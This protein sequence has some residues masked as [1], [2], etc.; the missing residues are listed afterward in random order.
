[1]CA[2]STKYNLVIPNQ[3]LE[4]MITYVVMTYIYIYIPSIIYPDMILIDASSIFIYV[5]TIS[6]K[7]IILVMSSNRSLRIIYI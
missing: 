5:M 6:M 2:A 3:E 4:A 7:A 1:M